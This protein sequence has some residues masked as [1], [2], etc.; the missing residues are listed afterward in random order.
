M[1]SIFLTQKEKD[2][3]AFKKMRR[4][5]RIA[6]L[7]DSEEFIAMA[8]KNLENLPKEKFLEMLTYT[9]MFHKDGTLKK[10]FR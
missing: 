2:L 10:E 4:G 3:L 6:T 9:R 1:R 8:K 5:F 7:E